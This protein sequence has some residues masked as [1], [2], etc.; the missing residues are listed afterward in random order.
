MAQAAY[1]PALILLSIALAVLASYTALSIAARIVVEREGVSSAWLWVGACITGF[2]LWGMHFVG[3]LAFGLPLPWGYGRLATLIALLIAIAFA[4]LALWLMTQPGLARW[5]RALGAVIVG[6][7]IAGM[8]YTGMEAVRISSSF[9]WPLVLLCFAAAV[10][11][12]GLGIWRGTRQRARPERASLRVWEA[13]AMGLGLS[14][15]YY[16]GMASAVQGTDAG[17]PS[18]AVSAEGLAATILGLSVV[19]SLAAIKLSASYAKTTAKSAQLASSLQ[20]ARH[21]LSYLNSHDSVTGAVNRRMFDKRLAAA[22]AAS[23]AEGGLLALLVIDVDSFRAVNEAYGYPVGDEVLMQT[24]QRLSQAAGPHDS[25]A[26][27]GG[28]EFVAV[29]VLPHTSYAGHV[30]DNYLAALR[31]PF[32]VA[33]QDIRISASVGIAVYPHDGVD[34]HALMAKAEAAKSYAKNLGRDRHAFFEPSMNAGSD[35]HLRVFEQLRLA[36]E[37]GELRLFYQ[38]KVKAQTAERVGVE[39]LLRWHNGELGDVSPAEFVPLAEQTGLILSLQTW[40]LDEACR[41]LAA[42]DRLGADIPTVAI[43]IAALQFQQNDFVDSIAAALKRHGLPAKRLVLEITETTAMKQA[44]QSVKIMRRL[45]AMG[46]GLSIDDFGT[47]YSSLSYLKRFPAR[48]LKIDREFVME[49]TQ[50]SED[51]S[52]VAAIVAAIV[53]LAHALRLSV[54]AEGVETEAQRR[55]LIDLGCDVLQGYLTGR[56]AAA[57]TFDPEAAAMLAPQPAG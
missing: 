36:V 50:D 3:M 34:P 26:R 55:L 29:A 28:D 23:R 57:W 44:A 27:L 30:A 8:H 1:S 40:V 52:I 41:Q 54:V 18:L 42:W 37:R 4:A 11:A 13:V 20:E 25:F 24:A 56:P 46:V 39:A 33:G 19:L 47:G 14:A 17:T 21:R 7:G 9:S 6:T 31:Q 53:A 2:G 43:N 32:T 22:I 10:F 51:V 16:S 48:E 38:P 5:E 12:A 35:R 45:Y 49:L 15:M